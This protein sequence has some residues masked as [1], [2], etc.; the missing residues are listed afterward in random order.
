MLISFSKIIGNSSKNNAVIILVLS[1]TD[2]LINLL[3]FLH[4]YKS[5]S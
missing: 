2:H 4:M 3:S 5:L 1:K